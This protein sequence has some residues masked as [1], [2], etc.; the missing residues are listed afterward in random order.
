M[1]KSLSNNSNENL[2]Q[3]EDGLLSWA[4]LIAVFC[5][6]CL[7]A[8]VFNVGRIANDKLEAQNAADAAAYSASLVQARAMNAITASNHLMGELTALYTLHHSMTDKRSRTSNFA[9]TS[10]KTGASIAYTLAFTAHFPTLLYGGRAP[11]YYSK[12]FTDNPRGHTTTYN[13]K[14]L[15]KYRAAEAYGL[16]LS[17]AFMWKWFVWKGN[18]FNPQPTC[19][20]GY[21]EPSMRSSTRSRLSPRTR[22]R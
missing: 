18:Q 11:V 7:I 22:F 15:L 5:F 19:S 14:C 12:F 10:L 13:S 2:W 8:M 9:V 3:S 21:C 6:C 17:S 20:S 1:N 16:H 4:T